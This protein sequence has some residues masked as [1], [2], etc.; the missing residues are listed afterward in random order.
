MT[1]EPAKGRLTQMAEGAGRP[2]GPETGDSTG[3]RSGRDGVHI[4]IVEDNAL[5]A[6]LIKDVLEAA[7]FTI[8]GLASS[9]AEALS[10]VEAAPPRLA[11]VDIRLP[12][13]RDG[14][15]LARELLDRFNVP[16]IFL[17]G[18]ADPAVLR[19][20][21]TAEPLGFLRKPFRPSQ[22]FNA[23]VRAIGLAGDD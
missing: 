14:I 21:R 22:V 2:S 16:S 13:P 15:D 10:I 9:A 17:S 23:V 5:V 19:R 11:L 3:K 20:A 8:A 6:A 18:T 7:G 1:A 4:L 12:G